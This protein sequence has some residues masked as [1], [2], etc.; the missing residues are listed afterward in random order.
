[1][2]LARSISIAVTVALSVFASAAHASTFAFP[3]ASSSYSSGG[4][5]VAAGDTVSETYINACDGSVR[6]CDGSVRICDGSVRSCDGSVRQVDLILTLAENSLRG[7][8]GFEVLLNGL[9]IGRFS[10]DGTSSI[11]TPFL[12]SFSGFDIAGRGSD[13]Q[14][15]LFALMVV[16]PVG[17]GEGAVSFDFGDPGSLVLH[18]PAETPIPA[19]LPLFISGLAGMGLLFGRKRKLAAC[20]RVMRRECARKRTNI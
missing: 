20:C 1:M 13:G 10:F 9:E 12:F 16:G 7:T 17:R 15:Y 8:L 5:F 19:S 2:L 14:E 11:G 18:D 4:S 3:T 6:T